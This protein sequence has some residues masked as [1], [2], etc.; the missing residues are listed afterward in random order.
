VQCSLWKY[1]VVNCCV[2]YF[3]FAL[4]V[5]GTISHLILVG[6]NKTVGKNIVYLL[7][8]GYIA[9]K[10]SLLVDILCSLGFISFALC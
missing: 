2:L 6:D 9:G 4:S 3:S 1:L 5:K 7:R 8:K 10:G